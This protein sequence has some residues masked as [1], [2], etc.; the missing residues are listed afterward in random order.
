MPLSGHTRGLSL[1]VS[2][3]ISALYQRLDLD[4]NGAVSLEELNTGLR[5]IHGSSNFR[6]SDDDFYCTDRHGPSGVGERRRSHVRMGSHVCWKRLWR[7]DDDGMDAVVIVSGC[8]FIAV[9]EDSEDS[10]EG[11]L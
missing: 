7:G 10:E 1:P 3:S 8:G 6:L 11:G 9:D 5:K 2:G 4:E